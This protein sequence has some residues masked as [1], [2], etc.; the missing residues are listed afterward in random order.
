TPDSED[1][2][3]K[4]V[5]PVVESSPESIE[6]SSEKPTLKQSSEQQPPSGPTPSEHQP[7]PEH[8]PSEHLHTPEPTASEPHTEIIPDQN[9]EQIV[10]NTVV[11][12]DSDFDS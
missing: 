8:Q 11:L 3:S 10:E 7:T 9:S 12:N 1:A 5:N 4:P 2:N 6:I